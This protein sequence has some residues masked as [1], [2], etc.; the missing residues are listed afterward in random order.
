ML[1][2]IVKYAKNAKTN[3]V[4]TIPKEKKW[5]KKLMPN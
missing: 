1:R 5:G 4:D 3:R 2:I